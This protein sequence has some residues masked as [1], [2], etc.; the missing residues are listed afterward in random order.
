MTRLNANREIVKTLAALV[1]CYPDMRFHQLLANLD[2]TKYDPHSSGIRVVRDEYH[3]ESE[4]VLE[5]IKHSSL[6]E[7]QYERD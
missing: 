2:V 7:V 4:V 6:L 3:V 5:R 1:E